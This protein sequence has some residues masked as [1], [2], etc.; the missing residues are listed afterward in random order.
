[1]AS[2][3]DPTSRSSLANDPVTGFRSFR[4]DEA[5]AALSWRIPFRGPVGIG[6]SL[7]SPHGMGRVCRQRGHAA[8][9]GFS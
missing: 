9:I 5:T 6:G 2:R 1:M 3:T 4:G 8:A 7:V